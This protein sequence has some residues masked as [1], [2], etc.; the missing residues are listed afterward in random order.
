[1]QD[2]RRE[3]T[4]SSWNTLERY[5]NFLVPY[6]DNFSNAVTNDLST[7]SP[8]LDNPRLMDKF[9]PMITFLA[10]AIKGNLHNTSWRYQDRDLLYVIEQMNSSMNT[11]HQYMEDLDEELTG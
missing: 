9:N 4:D 2:Y 7:I 3:R 1:M 6:V 11:I 5:C 10:G 8:F